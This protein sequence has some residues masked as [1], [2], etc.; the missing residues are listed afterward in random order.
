MKFCLLLLATLFLTSGAW[1]LRLE[2]LAEVSSRPAAGPALGLPDLVDLSLI[3]S[4]AAPEALPAY[5]AVYE[6]WEAES[7]AKADPAWDETRKAEELLLYLHSHLKSYST[8]Q[9]RLDVLADRGTYNCVSSALAYM[10]LGRAAGLDVQAVATSDHAFALVRLASGRAVDVETTTKYGFDPGT[11]TEFTNSFGQTG[12]AYVPPGNYAERRAIGDRQLLGL[13][14]QNRM[15]DLQR[16]GQLEEAVGP[17]IDRWVVEGTTEAFRTLVDGFVNYGSWLNGR[18]E[19][20]KGLDLVEKMVVWTGPVPEAKQ[21][22]FAFLN[23]AVNQYLDKRDWAGAQAL[24]VTW[25]NRGYLTEDQASQTLSLIGDNELTAAVKSLPPAQAAQRVEAAFAQGLIPSARRQ[26]LLSY[27]YG[28]EVQKIAASQG[29]QA[30]WTYL[31]GLPAEVQALPALAKARE[32]YAYNW[33]VD[34]H[35]QFAKLWNAGK[36]DQARQL[37]RDALTDLPGSAMLKKDLVLSQ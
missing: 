36:K 26:E 3:L 20:L 11:K 12:F 33:S 19:Y 16:S 7:Q 10:I 5:R 32:V 29:A 9:T 22:A 14:V 6:R 34:V 27:L 4:G 24:T 17:G 23:N 8:F 1:G 25:R 21:L 15:A 18:R 31:G 35:N 13:L 30:A 28:Q 2:P 37:L